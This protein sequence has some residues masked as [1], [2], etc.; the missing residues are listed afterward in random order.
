M[1]KDKIQID[2]KTTPREIEVGTP[3]LIKINNSWMR[4]QKDGAAQ[5]PVVVEEINFADWKKQRESKVS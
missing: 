1:L 3:T 5:Q 2:N 4:I